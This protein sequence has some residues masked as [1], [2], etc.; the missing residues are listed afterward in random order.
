MVPTT[1]GT[2]A[3]VAAASTALMASPLHTPEALA[4]Y[5]GITVAD[6]EDWLAAQI[7]LSHSG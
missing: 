3:S 5:M 2:S 7:E 1:T 6:V 4:A